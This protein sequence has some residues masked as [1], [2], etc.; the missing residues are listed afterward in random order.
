MS[1]NNFFHRIFYSFFL[2]ISLLFSNLS[3]QG[4]ILTGHVY[5]GVQSNGALIPVEGAQV[6]IALDSVPEGTIA[7]SER[8][9]RK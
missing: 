6:A 2:F 9:D 4:I 8:E 1:F 5:T 3:A 7:F